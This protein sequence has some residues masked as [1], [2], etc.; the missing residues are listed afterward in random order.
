MSTYYDILGVDPTATAASIK[1]A[2]RS[3]AMKQHPDRGGTHAQMVR[4]NEA[5]EVLS[6]PTLREQYDQLLASG[7][8]TSGRFAGA[9]NR[10][11][12]YPMSWAKFD[13][14][15]NAV[16]KDFTDAEYGKADFLGMNVPTGGS[17]LSGWIF[18]VAG[19]ALGLIAA[20][21]VYY[22]WTPESSSTPGAYTPRHPFRNPIVFKFGLVGL[23][24]GGAWLGQ[25]VHS[26][27]GSIIAFW[28]AKAA[29]WWPANAF[30]A[31]SGSPNQKSTADS[32]RTHQ[33]NSEHCKCPQCGQKLKLSTPDRGKAITCP[34]CRHQFKTSSIPQRN[35]KK[36]NLMQF[37]PDKETLAS[38]LKALVVADI[39]AVVLTM[40]LIFIDSA[41][42]SSYG[43]EI[44]PNETDVFL[45]GVYSAI[46][47]VVLPT[48]IACWVGL[49]KFKN[50]SRWLY[51]AL[52][53]VM[54][55]IAI[56]L[57]CLSFTVT[58][59]LTSAIF[60]LATPIEITILAVAFLSPLATEFQVSAA[61]S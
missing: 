55:L 34:K 40:P 28:F 36:V 6:D 46:M 58:W 61:D 54:Y 44:E 47:L 4:V 60:D 52:T 50:W 26:T 38:I 3:E 32:S 24:A 22:I 49:L 48:L 2:Y 10:A 23:I 14:W 25:I 51:L 21:V 18:I 27:F 42:C 9:R 41:I 57:G 5:W 13:K 1:T 17:S 30:Q 56:P 20:G 12:N 33:D 43:Y 39:V 8:S 45:F 16:G 7:A 59:G 11:A 15:L 35:S 31:I 53:V 19:G 37:P 29:A